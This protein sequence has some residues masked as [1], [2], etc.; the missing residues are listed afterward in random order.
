MRK[1]SLDRFYTF[2]NVFS[3]NDRYFQ[4]SKLTSFQRQLN[5]YGFNRLTQGRDRGGYYHEYFLR[6]RPCL[7]KHMSRIRIKGIKVK[8]ANSPDQEPDFYALPVVPSCVSV[9]STRTTSRC[10]SATIPIQGNVSRDNDTTSTL[11]DAT[12]YAIPLS[13]QAPD[14]FAL[15]GD[16]SFVSSI[17]STSICDPVRC[18]SV[19]SR[20]DVALNNNDA[21]NDATPQSEQE[22]DFYAQPSV[23]MCALT[24]CEA[25]SEIPRCDSPLSTLTQLLTEEHVSSGN[26]ATAEFVDI[27]CAFPQPVLF[28]ESKL[29]EM[30]VEKMPVDEVT[31]KLSINH[32]L[33]RGTFSDY[34][35]DSSTLAATLNNDWCVHFALDRLIGS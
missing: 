17:T 24:T 32:H 31:D 7:S 13:V 1:V 28:P 30:L 10:D 33:Q 9:T 34:N 27:E 18:D 8:A 2:T 14:F 23:A 11:T 22:P 6:G 29:D 4:Q 3:C 25:A 35:E 5:L 26:T 12:H 19:T 20:K 16:A 21:S 15:P